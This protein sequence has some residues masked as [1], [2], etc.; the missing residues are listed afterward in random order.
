MSENPQ[1]PATEELSE[2][3]LGQ[4]MADFMLNGRSIRDIQGLN[5]EQMEAI[6]ATGYTLY[7]GGRYEDAEKIFHCLCIFDHLGHRYW[8]GL[9][10]ARQMLK[11]HKE[12]IDAYSMAAVLDVR[13]PQAALQSAEC[14]LA[15][16]NLEGAK[17]GLRCA[18]EYAGGNHAAKSRAEALLSFL[19]HNQAQAPAGA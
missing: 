8:M 5:D 13:D 11:K 7:K 12:A 15:L 18:I 1:N 16:G 2:E 19:E 17:S 9:G 3:Q 10:S 4:L 14:H 6:Y